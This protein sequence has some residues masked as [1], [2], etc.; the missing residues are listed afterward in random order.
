MPA[1]RP[2]HICFWG[3]RGSLCLSLRG[4]AVFAFD[5]SESPSWSWPCIRAACGSVDVAAVNSSGEETRARHESRLC[6][7]V[8]VVVVVVV[9][10]AWAVCEAMFNSCVA[11]AGVVEIAGQYRV[12]APTVWLYRRM[13]R[14]ECDGD[15]TKGCARIR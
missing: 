6:F 5:R 15:S 10:V 11:A 1:F 8:V 4:F 12:R 9:M 3:R 2:F 14:S 13:R 7:G